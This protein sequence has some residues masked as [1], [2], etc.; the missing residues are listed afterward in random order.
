MTH[1][2]GIGGCEAVQVTHIP[3][4]VVLDQVT[5]HPT[6]TYVI[7]IIIN[8]ISNIYL[9]SHIYYKTAWVKGEETKN[10]A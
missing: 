9:F 3:P 2:V 1:F 4:T 10:H 8:V 6:W 7:I 5:Q